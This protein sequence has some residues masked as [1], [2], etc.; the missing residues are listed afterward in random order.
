MLSAWASC[1]V[2]AARFSC[3]RCAREWR[4]QWLPAV[5]D[6]DVKRKQFTEQQI[7]AILQGVLRVQSEGVLARLSGLGTAT[8]VALAACGGNASDTPD[9]SDA[10]AFSAPYVGFVA[11]GETRTSG[12]ITA[13]GGCECP[14]QPP[15]FGECRV[16]TDF[17]IGCQDK[18]P[19]CVDRNV[20]FAPGESPL[21]W[22][23]AGLGGF[24]GMIFV[25]TYEAASGELLRIDVEGCHGTLQIDR[26]IPALAT[27]VVSAPEMDGDTLVVTWE[28]DMTADEVEIQVGLGASESLRCR[29]EDSGELRLPMPTVSPTTLFVER[30]FRVG[31]HESEHADITFF[32]SATG[33]WTAPL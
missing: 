18:C 13:T 14:Q 4:A 15:V 27:V 33:M 8:V 16:E 12:W 17:V 25:S 28:T 31:A 2:P 7:I 10:D 3:R 23:W 24:L 32:E 26:T 22:E 1:A 20:V 19:Q 6:C 9:A 11:V 30:R 29:V 5:G 21:A